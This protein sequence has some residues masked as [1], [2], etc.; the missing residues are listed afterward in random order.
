VTGT[1]QPQD[2]AVPPR[3]ARVRQAFTLAG[4]VGTAF[5][6]SLCC[7]GPL[8]FVALGV[9]AGL[10]SRFEPLRPV[11]TVLTLVLLAFGFYTVYGAPRRTRSAAAACAPGAACAAPRDRTRDRWILWVATVIAVV[12]LTFPQWS[13]LLT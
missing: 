3:S 2:V 4:A 12:I 7:I 8:L 11:F 1:A 10:A 13:L 5:L 6:A 9:G